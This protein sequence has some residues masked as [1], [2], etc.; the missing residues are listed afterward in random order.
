VDVGA[1]RL[2][3]GV[4]E[5]VLAVEADQRVADR[6]AGEDHEVPGALD[7]VEDEVELVPGQLAGAEP[8]G[9]PPGPDGARLL[10]LGDHPHRRAGRAEQR[11]VAGVVGDGH[12]GLGH[13]VEED[14]GRVTE[15]LVIAGVVADLDH[16]VGAV[17][18]GG[19]G[20][21]VAVVEDDPVGGAGGC[22]GR[23]D[24]DGREGGDGAGEQADETSGTWGHGATSGG[25]GWD[26]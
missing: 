6:T 3:A 22:G 8:L 26:R 4:G 17:E 19:D 25:M 21:D 12:L 18:T 15:H 2:D 11:G 23:G 7:V 16:E 9:A 1:D 10:D 14:V 24:Q 13:D 5:T 20:V